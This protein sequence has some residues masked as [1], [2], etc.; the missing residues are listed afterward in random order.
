MT[1]HLE[2]PWMTTTR[3]SKRP[4]KKWASAA[5]KQRAEQEAREWSALKQEFVDRA[6]NFSGRRY[7]AP[8]MPRG[9]FQPLKTASMYP[10]GR[11]PQQHIPSRD[12]GVGVAAAPA[13][14]V[15][16]GTKIKG[17]GTMHKSNAVPIFSDEEAQ[18][19]ARMRR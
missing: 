7:P 17:I 11:E 18:D 4:H 5:A 19:I 6:P 1:M 2:G 9:A 16:T 8:E 15:Y 3:Y 14:K 10:P 13:A 12:S